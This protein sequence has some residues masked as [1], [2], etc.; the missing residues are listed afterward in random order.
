[1]GFLAFP[2]FL[3]PAILISYL[4]Y[5]GKQFTINYSLQKKNCN[6]LLLKTSNEELNQV[7]ISVYLT[8]VYK[9]PRWSTVLN[10]KQFGILPGLIGPIYYSR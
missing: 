5:E 3:L 8:Q 2:M 6:E 10:T 1:M 9:I 4:G 7:L